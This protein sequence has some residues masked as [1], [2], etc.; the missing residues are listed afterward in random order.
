MVSKGFTLSD[1]LKDAAGNDLKYIVAPSISPLEEERLQAQRTL[2][3]G[4]KSSEIAGL[5]PDGVRPAETYR[6][7]RRNKERA[8]GTLNDPLKADFRRFLA[9][10]WRHLKLPTPS[11]VQLSLAW[12][13]QHGPTRAVI[14]GFRGMAKSWITG[15]FILRNLYC[16]PQRKI[17]VVSA[18]LDRAVQTREAALGC[19]QDPRAAGAPP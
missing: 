19:S 13:L 12:W 15:A 2:L 11:P 16:D 9:L 17:L 6:G 14:L 4:M 3:K 1:P 10:I 7:A 18:S 5:K 8:E